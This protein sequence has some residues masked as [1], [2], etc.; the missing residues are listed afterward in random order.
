MWESCCKNQSSTLLSF[1]SWLLF[2]KVILLRHLLV[3]LP[4][5][6]S[7]NLLWCSSGVYLLSFFS[8]YIPLPKAPSTL[9]HL[10]NTCRPRIREKM[11]ASILWG[12]SFP[13]SCPLATVG[14]RT[15]HPSGG[16]WPLKDRPWKKPAQPL[17]RDVRSLDREVHVWGSWRNRA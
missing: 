11:E 16:T 17:S 3:C 12:Q 5:Q 1:S 2:S 9:Q 10:P 15:T 8:Y 13:N 7:I 6:S 14:P 4:I